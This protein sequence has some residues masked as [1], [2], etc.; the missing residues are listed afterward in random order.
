MMPAS[1]ERIHYGLRPAKNIER[2][3]LCEVFRRLSA[4]A[5]VET[6]RYIG[7]GSTYFSDFVLF[8][9][10]LDIKNMISIEHD[11]QK[12]DRFKF[13]RPFGC[14]EIEFGES[15][16]VLASLEWD[17]K[18]ILW[19]DYDSKLDATVLADVAFFCA[20]AVP[21]SFVAIT[22][23]AHPDSK[24]GVPP[25]ELP[26]YRAQELEARVLK[27][28]VPADITGKE[29]RGWGTAKACRRIINNKIEQTLNERNG[30]R[31]A[32]PAFLYQQLFNFH[33]ADNAKMLTVGGLL[34]DEGLSDQLSHCGF[35]NLR[36]FR[37]DDKPYLIRVPNLTY[38]EIRHLAEQL[39]VNDPAELHA[40]AI[41]QKD[42][43]AYRE[44][45][46]YFPTFAEA[47]I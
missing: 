3:M 6:Y 16:Q 27:E 19:L 17:L 37:S 36:F 7:F 39:P 15:T 21:G 41:P 24:E 30:G 46:R 33:Y 9:K 32:A 42:L 35:H 22:V 29:L 12:T 44:V 34:I 20:N 40:Q 1:Y 8:H 43:E 23:N 10:A 2:K 14:I 45:Y 26:R 38:K 5:R 18:T 11:A 28:N 13:N 31:Q 25:L 4:F 47:E